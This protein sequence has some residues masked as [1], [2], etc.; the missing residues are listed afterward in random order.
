MVVRAGGNEEVVLKVLAI[1]IK[2]YIDAWIEI[3]M[4]HP[5]KVRYMSLPAKRV[6]TY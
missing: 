4:G 6:T 2:C 1:P 5:P 3:R